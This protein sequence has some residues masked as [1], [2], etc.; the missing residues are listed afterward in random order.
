MEIFD[1]AEQAQLRLQANDRAAGKAARLQEQIMTFEATA[2]RLC[3]PYQDLTYRANG[4]AAAALQLMQAVIDTQLAAQAAAEESEAKLAEFRLQA[5][6]FEETAA[7]L[8]AKQAQWLQAGKAIDEFQFLTVLEQS[9]RL[10]EIEHELF[11]LDAQLTAGRSGSKQSELDAL[12]ASYKESELQAKYAE[13]GE[14]L[15]AVELQRSHLLEQSGRKRQQLEQLLRDNDRQRLTADR[16]QTIASLEQL[17]SRYAVLSISMTMMKRTKRLMEEQRQPGVLR[18]AS[19]WMNLL[20]EG[21]YRRISI[22]EGEQTISLENSDGRIVESIFLSR[23][24]AE[25]LYLAMRFALADEAAGAS[26][27]PLLLDDPF[28]NFDDGRLKAAAGV[29]EEIAARRQLIFFTCHAH[30]RDLLL[31]RIPAAQLIRLG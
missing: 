10:H 29:L 8:R 21:R 6:R 4:D 14:E 18:E 7:A 26:A 5:D 19:R 2:N 31:A 25:Q 3:A 12:Y 23:G 13:T 15:Q 9:E 11:K 27:L 24:T 1:L 28:V 16:E 30:V 22:P 17:I 20:S